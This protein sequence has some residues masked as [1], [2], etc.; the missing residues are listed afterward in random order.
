MEAIVLIQSLVAPY[1]SLTRTFPA[2]STCLHAPE[3]EM[4]ATQS[5]M[6]LKEVAA[7]RDSLFAVEADEGSHFP[8][9]LHIVNTVIKPGSS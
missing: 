3:N 7:F 4:K 6:F 1:H 9:F 8:E 5:I 2:I